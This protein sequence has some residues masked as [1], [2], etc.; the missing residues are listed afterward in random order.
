MTSKVLSKCKISPQY[1]RHTFGLALTICGFSEVTRLLAISERR[2]T[3][4][5]ES[6]AS[7]RIRFSDGEQLLTQIRLS[8]GVQLSRRR[9][10]FPGESLTLLSLD[11]LTC[12]K[13][14]FTE[15][16]SSV[17]LCT[18]CS[19]DSLFSSLVT[20]DTGDDLLSGNTYRIG[21]PSKA[22]RPG[23]VMPA[24]IDDD[25]GNGRRNSD[26]LGLNGG[27]LPANA[28]ENTNER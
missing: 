16:V 5:V 13:A 26:R 20:V 7:K 15:T 2:S 4:L 17:E 28:K 19:S 1:G 11:D 8:G 22:F 12:W 23:G 3:G 24:T 10:R 21:R 14:D 6:H 9:K 25:G 18:A 27:K